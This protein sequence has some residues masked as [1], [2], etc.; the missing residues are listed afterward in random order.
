MGLNP[1][2]SLLTKNKKSLGLH[3]SK[4]GQFS[5]LADLLTYSSVAQIVLFTVSA[6]LRNSHDLAKGSRTPETDYA[7]PGVMLRAPLTQAALPSYT[8]ETSRVGSPGLTQDICTPALCSALPLEHFQGESIFRG[9]L[10]IPVSPYTI[11]LKA[12]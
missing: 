11:K 7:N 4:S 9:S 2:R 6:V 3:L 12:K 8:T 5:C 10:E 1:F